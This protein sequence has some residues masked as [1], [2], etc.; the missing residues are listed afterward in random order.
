MARNDTDKLV[1]LLF[2]MLPK[3]MKGYN[4]NRNEIKMDNA[5][6]IQSVK[7]IY[8]VIKKL[9]LVDSSESTEKKKKI[10]KEHVHNGKEKEKSI[11]EDLDGKSKKENKVE[12]HKENVQE[13]I[14]ESS[15]TERFSS[16]VENKKDFKCQCGIRDVL[17]RLI[18]KKI[19][20]Y[21]ADPI[22]GLIDNA[23][24]LKIKNNIIELKTK[25]NT[26]IMLLIDE[27]VGIKSSELESITFN[28]E[29]E[30]FDNSK[31]CRED[32]FRIY[33]N[34]IVGKKAFIQT[35]GC[36][37]LRYMNNKIITSV[38]NDFV[39]IENNILLSLKKIVLVEI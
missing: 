27:I 28:N 32:E 6:D 23:V 19:T 1:E 12:E 7:E 5:I 22:K 33:F 38:G 17:R 11:K 39:V 37:E 21:I 10:D 25:E 4:E 18:N 14:K 13:E 2:Y 3:Y 26:K 29:G 15:S 9:Q 31:R 16:R 24:V 20:F 35:K 36:E 8:D 30:N 34:S